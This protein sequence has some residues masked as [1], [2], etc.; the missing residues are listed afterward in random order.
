M[1]TLKESIRYELAGRF[2]IAG[3]EL[4]FLAGGREDSDGIVFTTNKSG[5]TCNN[6]VHFHF[7]HS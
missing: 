6:D 7:L 3:E 5:T 1:K 2:G 4:S